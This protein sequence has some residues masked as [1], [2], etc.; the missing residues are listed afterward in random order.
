MIR[1]RSFIAAASALIPS[2]AYAADEP[3]PI[4]I[5]YIQALTGPNSSAGI[6]MRRGIDFAVEEINAA[7][8]VGG[9][10][11]DLIVR[12]TQGDPTRAVNSV[13]ELVSRLH[14]HVLIGPNNSGE[15]L[16]TAAIL[17]RSRTPQVHSASVD[18]LIDPQK[19][20]NAFRTTGSNSQWES[21]ANRYVIEVLK[22]QDVAVIA[23]NTGYGTTAVQVAVGDVARRGGKVVYSNMV[24]LTTPDLSTEII[25]AKSAGAKAILAWTTGAGLL[26]RLLNARG[27]AGWNVPVAGHPSLGSGEL[28]HL[29]EK[30]EYWDNVYQVSFRPCCFDAS[31]NLPPRAAAFVQQLAGKV[32]VKDSTLWWVAWGY[33]MIGLAADAVRHTGKSTPDAIINYWNTL[34]PYA[35][36][37]GN[38]H[39][40]P[41]QH[42]GYPQSDIAMATSNS[43]RDG[44]YT[45][46]KGY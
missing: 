26:A 7:G 44:A 11:I 36:I 28:L 23:D 24:D 4:R 25:R 3:E 18:S 6:G 30:P 38:Y 10:K 46:A 43:F 33:D 35:G 1:R 2:V 27:A 15:T 39:F 34:N 41:E 32:N 19:F 45:I 12:D 13:Q 21:A 20:P 8:G 9:R 42:D 22:L 40:S 16:A 29:L 5:G 31:G 17:A 37:Y 14:A